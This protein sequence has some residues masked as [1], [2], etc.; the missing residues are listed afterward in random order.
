LQHP[1]TYAHYGI[2]SSLNNLW[3][4]EGLAQWSQKKFDVVFEFLLVIPLKVQQQKR[5]ARKKKLA[6]GCAFKKGLVPLWAD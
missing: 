4:S 1:L 2:E 5:H 3:W 6:E